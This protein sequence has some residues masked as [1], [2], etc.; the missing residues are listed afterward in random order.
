MPERIISSS[1][2]RSGVSCWTTDRHRLVLGARA[3]WGELRGPRGSLKFWPFR[4]YCGDEEITRDNLGPIETTVPFRN[5][6]WWTDGKG[7]YRFENIP[8]DSYRVEVALPKGKLKLQ[9]KTRPSGAAEHGRRDATPPRIAP[10]HAE[11][12]YTPSV[13]DEPDEN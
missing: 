1:Q 3:L 4:L 7:R 2:A 9:Q 11:E 8:N 5:H 13:L 10:I 6:R 12:P